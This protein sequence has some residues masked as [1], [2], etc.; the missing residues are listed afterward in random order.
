MTNATHPSLPARGWIVSRDKVEN[1]LNAIVQDQMD[2]L[3]TRVNDALNGRSF[4]K[5][6]SVAVCCH[7]FLPEV[8]EA[9]LA[10]SKAAGWPVEINMH[11]FRDD[12]PMS[13]NQGAPANRVALVFKLK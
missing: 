12:D 4:A 1:E 11:A 6:E 8:R 10:Q 7:E 9:V 5:Q 13:A 2:K 3:R